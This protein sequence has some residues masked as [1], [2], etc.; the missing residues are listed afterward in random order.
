MQKIILEILN[1]DNNINFIFYKNYLNILVNQLSQFFIIDEIKNFSYLNN[2][3]QYNQKYQFAKI[4]SD[5]ID[6][7]HVEKKY[8]VKNN[9]LSIYVN[10]DLN[11]I[12]NDRMLSILLICFENKSYSFFN[13]TFFKNHNSEIH[14]LHKNSEV[15]EKENKLIA[16]KDTIIIL[17]LTQNNIK[18]FK[19]VFL[20]K[21]SYINTYKVNNLTYI[22]FTI[23]QN[24]LSSINNC[25]LKIKDTK[26][27][28][29]S[30]LLERGY[31]MSQIKKIYSIFDIFMSYIKK[32]II[33]HVTQN[34]LHVNI[35]LYIVLVFMSL[36]LLWILLLIYL[37]QKIKSLNKKLIND[38]TSK[39]VIQFESISL[40]LSS[41]LVVIGTI[42]FMKNN[43]IVFNDKITTL[44]LLIFK[45]LPSVAH[46][47][48]GRTI[49]QKQK[50][51]WLANLVFVNYLIYF[52]ISIL[53]QFN[54][55]LF[56]ISVIIS[57]ILKS[58]HCIKT[59]K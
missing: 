21:D 5:I 19:E 47:I 15:K 42:F 54:L 13:R 57:N 49:Y 20:K 35:L 9:I 18:Y 6:I 12:Y 32:L 31:S 43:I 36:L 2:V 27:L 45:L 59:I 50:N 1:K 29:I 46:C 38:N 4:D 14:I 34:Q 17:Y 22:D 33:D 7:I 24:A 44:P 8:D 10:S 23:K 30:D 58:I 56:S 41:S 55:L 48:S 16:K 39:F 11:Y 3:F 25:V 40:L 28:L 53:S 52:N 37:I 51:Q 26:Q